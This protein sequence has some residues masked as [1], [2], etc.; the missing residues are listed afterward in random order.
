MIKIVIAV[1]A[2]MLLAPTVQAAPIAPISTDSA[3]IQVRFG[4]GPGRTRINGVCVARTTV[5]HTRRE[6]RRAY[7]RAPVY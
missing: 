2:F 6:M 5:R 3:I 1:T 7:R 4:C